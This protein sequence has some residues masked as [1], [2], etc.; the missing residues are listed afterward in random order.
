[1]RL[2]SCDVVQEGLREVPA[3]QLNA[4]F[5]DMKKVEPRSIAC[6][7]NLGSRNCRAHLAGTRLLK[8]RPGRPASHEFSEIVPEG[9]FHFT[10]FRAAYN[11]VP[12]RSHLDTVSSA[13]PS[14]LY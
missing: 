9:L 1:M 12:K 14:I 10:D 5:P 11:I 7:T 4:S 6:P 13:S 2:Q 8:A 3:Y